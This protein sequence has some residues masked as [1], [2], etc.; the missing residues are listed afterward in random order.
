MNKE[1][2]EILKAK[3]KIES[4]KETVQPTVINDDIIR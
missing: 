1:V 2:S 4:K 3:A